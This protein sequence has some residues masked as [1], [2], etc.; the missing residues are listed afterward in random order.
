MTACQTSWH[1]LQLYSGIAGM[2]ALW[3]DEEWT[4]LEIHQQLGKA[5]G[6]AY[7]SCRQQGIDDMSSLVLALSNNLLAFNYRDTFTSAF[8]VANKV[9]E[10]L[11]MRSGVDVCCTG[12]DDVTRIE[13]YNSQQ[14]AEGQQ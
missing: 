8:E 5:A 7:V 12:D 6:D 3:L 11:M 1:P 4:P 13:R 2:I 9:V 10:M 14:E